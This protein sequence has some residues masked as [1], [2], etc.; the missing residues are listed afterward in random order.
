MANLETSGLACAINSTHS[1]IRGV[2]FQEQ[3]TQKI[4]AFAMI[5]DHGNKAPNAKMDMG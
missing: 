5:F 3:E 2:R 1:L 4:E